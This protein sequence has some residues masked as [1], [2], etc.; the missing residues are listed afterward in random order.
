MVDDVVLL[1][2]IVVFLPFPL[3]DK[4]LESQKWCT[5]KDVRK[6][7]YEKWRTKNG[8]RKMTDEKRRTKMAYKNWRMK[9]E[10]PKMAYE[11]RRTKIGRTLPPKSYTHPPPPKKNSSKLD[12]QKIR[13]YQ[14]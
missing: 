10:V 9:N 3:L 2:A 13:V 6:T 7:V 5:R 11:K 4:I 14:R 1:K 8:V 12:R